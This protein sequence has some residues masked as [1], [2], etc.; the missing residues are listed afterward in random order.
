MPSPTAARLEEER[1]EFLRD[2]RKTLGI[3]GYGSIGTQLS[4]LAEGLGMKVI[5][6]DVV[7]KLPLG[8]AQQ[9]SGLN[10]LLAQ[11]DHR[12]PACARELASTNGMMGSGADCR[13]EARQHSHQC[14]ARHGGRY[15][16]AGGIAA[17]RQAAGAAI[18]VFPKRNQEQQGRILSR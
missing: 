12:H 2:P 15:R 7:I 4:V 14:I 8:N 9:S 13:H 11:S 10:E 5:F 16:G 1:G 3:V 17:K 6:H 18:D